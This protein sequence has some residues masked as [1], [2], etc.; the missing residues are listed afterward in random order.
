LPTLFF[1]ILVNN[2]LGGEPIKLVAEHLFP[3]G[4]K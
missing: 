4:A 2:H 1:P 3:L